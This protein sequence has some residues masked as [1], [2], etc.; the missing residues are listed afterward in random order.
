MLASLALITIRILKLCIKPFLKLHWNIYGLEKGHYLVVNDLST[1]SEGVSFLRYAV[2]YH[3][4][5]LLSFD[6]NPRIKNLEVSQSETE[7]KTQSLTLALLM[8]QQKKCLTLL[9]TCQRS[10]NKIKLG[11]L[12]WPSNTNWRERSELLIL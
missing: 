10:L 8:Q 3:I 6:F 2:T 7:M 4:L 9:E 5:F 12:H 1:Y 11:S